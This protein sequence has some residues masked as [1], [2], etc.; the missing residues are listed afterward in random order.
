MSV[1][2][3]ML[4][5]NGAPVD[6]ESVSLISKQLKPCGFDGETSYYGN[7][8]GVVYRAFHTTA[9]SRHEVQPSISASGAVLI[10]DGRLDNRE[11][12]IAQL[13]DVLAGDRTDVAIVTA[14]FESWGTNC[15]SRFVGDWALSVWH[16]GTRT[17]ILS[18]DYAGIRHLFYYPKSHCVV[19]CTDL[20]PLVLCG[21]QFRLCD[22]YFAGYL[23]LWP[24]SHLTPYREVYPVPPGTFVSFH[25]GQV[26]VRKYWAFNFHR[27][28]RYRA[29]A[30]YEEHFR[31]AF[32]TAVKRRLRSDGPILADLSGGLDSSS[33]VCMADD[34]RH[35]RESQCPP[36]DTF[37]VVL[38]DEPGEE[39]SL[40]IPK[41][42]QQ[43]GRSGHHLTISCLS[44]ASP[45]D[46][47]D[48]IATPGFGTS[49][50]E[51]DFV[52][53]DIIRQGK[54]R[55]LL[56]GI[57]GDEMLGQALDPRIQ[58]ADLLRQCRLKGLGS[59]LLAW[60]LLLRRPIM[61]L[62][63]DALLLQL[64]HSIR[65]GCSEIAQ[66]EPWV[67]PR[68]ADAH[69]LKILQL[70]AAEAPWF[71]RPGAR[72]WYQ[73]IMT[74]TRLMSSARPSGEETRYPYL[75]RDL[76]EFLISIPTEQLLRPG[77]RRSLMRR[78]LSSLLPRDVLERRTK[79]NS[80]R[81]FCAALD[82]HWSSLESILQHPLIAQ[83]GYV[84]QPEFYAALRSAK[85]GDIPNHFLRVI[86]ALSWELWL[87]E[88]VSRGVFADSFT[89]P[90]GFRESLNGNTEFFYSCQPT[91]SIQVG[92][93]S[94][95]R[96]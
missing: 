28:L 96:R 14:A 77:H 64:P 49:R 81:Y 43:R 48:F 17:L 89:T 24:P 91:S 90:K 11:E 33:I 10:W 75:D 83:L 2:L 25:N 93:L 52:K 59:Q 47:P 9:E 86:R 16:P 7:S 80:S 82:K 8:I 71:W 78:S 70:E 67:N 31:S 58:L 18:R 65:A 34:I 3:G 19:W 27:P 39:D 40:Y 68:F 62:F 72:D 79:V 26:N 50:L 37:S 35:Q 63:T 51:I 95:E 55:V 22:E 66:L 6:R 87:R 13:Q 12:L 36:L 69:S 15:F 61:H 29:E 54:Y 42:E 46:Y 53:A 32:R 74:L 88:S 4:S 85:H 44:E 57:G 56:S 45:F 60:S 30:E 94:T 41:V 38:G 92:H 1:Q 23:A 73:T 21:D 84:K 76:V 5:L 20:E